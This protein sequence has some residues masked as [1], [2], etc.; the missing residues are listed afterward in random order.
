MTKRI[1]I[2]DDEE[3]ARQ[4]VKDSLEDQGY[5]LFEA[6]SGNEAL[7][8]AREVKPDLVI[9][10]LMMPDKW[11]YKVCEEL[12]RN[13]ETREAIVVFLSARGSAPSKKMGGLKSGDDFITKPF[14]PASLREKVKA[15]LESD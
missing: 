5:E 2:V 12:K 3:V 6:A 4:L 7:A 13:Q 8:K 14:S 15:L 11:G 10:D 1:L 9:L